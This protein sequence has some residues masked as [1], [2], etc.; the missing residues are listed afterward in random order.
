MSCEIVS[1]NKTAEPSQKSPFTADDY[2]VEDMRTVAILPFVEVHLVIFVV[3]RLSRTW[4][5][6]DS[7]TRKLSFVA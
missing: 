7:A 3:N 1:L 6:K 2:V 4:L 5:T